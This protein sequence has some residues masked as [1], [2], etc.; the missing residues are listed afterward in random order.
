MPPT[1]QYRILYALIVGLIFA[2]QLHIGALSATPQAALI[3]GNIFTLLVAP[4]LGAM[5]RLK[6]TNKLNDNT[7]ELI[8]DKPRQFRFA[9]GQYLEWTL[10]HD[11]T[12]ARGNRR[13]FSIASSPSELDLRI[14]IKTYAPSS[15]FKTAL[16]AVKPGVRIRGAHVNGSFTLPW[17]AKQ[18][19]VFVAGGVGITPFRSMLQHMI[20]K[21][22]QRDVTL[23]YIA[24]NESDFVY[25]DV[26]EQAKL[27][28]LTVHYVIGRMNEQALR[29]EQSVFAK[30]HVYISGPDAFVTSYKQSLVSLGVPRINIKTDH[31]TGY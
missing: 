15:S 2:S 19:L 16:L 31:F 22:D 9:A 6:Q 8:F 18:P 23:Y 7:Y 17:D 3:V 13:T 4:P 21:G 28:G 20:D 24:S 30:A 10:P 1:R 5:V 12:D 26:I 14:G 27:I 25:K 11:H 29:Q